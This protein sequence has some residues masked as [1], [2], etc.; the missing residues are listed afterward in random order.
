LCCSR[1][2][3]GDSIPLPAGALEYRGVSQSLLQLERAGGTLR[4]PAR[5]PAGSFQLLAAAFERAKLIE[6]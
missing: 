6:K 1:F 3:G 2:G 4:P 5:L